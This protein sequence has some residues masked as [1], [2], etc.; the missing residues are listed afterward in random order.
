MGTG[1]VLDILLLMLA[2]ILWALHLSYFFKWI[3]S[4]ARKDFSKYTINI[5]N[6]PTNKIFWLIQYFQVLFEKVDMI[7]RL[8]H[9]SKL[10]S[11]FWILIFFGKKIIRGPLYES[12]CDRYIWHNLYNISGFDSG[13]F[14]RGFSFIGHNIKD[15]DQIGDAKICRKKCVKDDRCSAWTYLIS[16]KKCQLKFTTNLVSTFNLDFISGPKFCKGNIFC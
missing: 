7:W 6:F 13:C 11:T 9:K 10:I 14:R 2:Y 12:T 1:M 15:L 16:I 4:Q 3:A 5:S 8:V